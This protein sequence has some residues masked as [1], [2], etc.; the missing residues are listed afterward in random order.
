MPG[1]P[2]CKPVLVQ[3]TSSQW[4]KLLLIKKFWKI[5]P[6]T[7]RNSYSLNIGLKRKRGKGF[8]VFMACNS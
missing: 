5:S 8:Y 4:V 3:M 7:L 2:Q 6:G 1:L